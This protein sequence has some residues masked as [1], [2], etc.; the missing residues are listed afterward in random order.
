MERGGW[1][2]GG[3]PYNGP[4]GVLRPKGVYVSCLGLNERVGI[5]RVKVWKRIR[6]T[7]IYIFK[8]V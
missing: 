5:P 8:R 6:K 2:G 4:Y 3:P 7:V 1:G